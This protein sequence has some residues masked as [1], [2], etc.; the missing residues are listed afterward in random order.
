VSEG[1]RIIVVEDSATQALKLQLMLEREGFTAVCAYTA[2]EAMEELNRQLPHLLIVDYHLPGIQGDEFCRQV[3][4][5]LSTRSI[6]ILMLTADETAAT[7]L[8]GLESGADDF[9]SK[10]EDP[11]ILLLRVH[12][13]L[14]RSRQ[15]L[16]IAEMSRP[17]FR[18]PRVLVIDDSDTYRETL[19]HELHEEGCD[20][21]QV[22]TGWDGLDKV[23]EGEFDCVLVDM[24]MPELDGVEVCQELAKKRNSTESPIVILMV[25]A[26]E[27]KE[28]VAR[29][30]EAGADDFV[31]KS[32]QM[33]VLRARLRALLRRK[34][35]LEENQRIIEEF[36]QK[37]MEAFRATAEKEAAEGRAALADGL[38]K[39]NAELAES[40]RKLKEA[41]L[42]LIQSEKMASLGQLVAGIA[43]EINNPLSFALS[44]V[45]TIQQWLDEV[46][47]DGGNRLTEASALRLDKARTR[48]KD[49][50]QGLDRV[51]DLVLQLRTFSRLDEGEFKTIDVREAFESVILFL[52]HKM[53]DRI[54][55]VRDFAEDNRLSCFAGQLNQVLM[56]VVANAVDAIDG[57]GT[58]TLATSRQGEMFEISV[59]DSG[60]GISAEIRERI[61]DPFF[62]T[63]GVGQGTGLGLA[64]SYGIV[65][66]HKGRIEV[67]SDQGTG[68]R[69]RILIPVDLQ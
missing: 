23:A 7:E 30:L 66:A 15:S 39:A 68:T 40:N 4:L 14:R 46:L 48:T 43:H 63:K 19:V 22:Q 2:E 60:K 6:P 16:S 50:G 35:L 44:N 9:V 56:N 36:K 57:P 20:V 26:Y 1:Q 28:N 67:D 27:N 45:F 18:R 38:A 42:H 5:N 32:T 31:G 51:R 3:H 25:S 58:I 33:S 37:E 69:M 49:S 29:A 17:R 59:Q 55:L 8:H 62:T 52:R 10:T 65:Q 54:T 61:F 64:I 12:N 41:Q 21:V 47:A 24:V 13:L 34:F 11:E 53:G